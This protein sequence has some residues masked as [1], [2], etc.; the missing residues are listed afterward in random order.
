MGVQTI[1]GLIEREAEEE[2]AGIVAAAEQASAVLVADAEVSVAARVTEALDRHG[3]EIRAESQRRINT[4]RLRVL[5]D[6]ARLD[7]ERLG[8]VFEAAE[9]RARGIADGDDVPRWSVALATLG[10][11]ALESVGRGAI[12][13][14]RS[15][16]AGSLADLAADRGA[17]IEKADAEAPAGVVVTS[18]D[19]RI[20]IDA[21][22]P[23]R[24]ERA[25]MLLAENVAAALAL[26]PGEA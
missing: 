2:A 18:A 26:R 16:D 3:T 14:V 21:S 4:V 10:E 23:V 25:R 22:L 20:R 19:G 13:S 8:S 24:L 7:A 15:H 5:E 12:L 6:R 9:I 11:D 17:Q 1:I